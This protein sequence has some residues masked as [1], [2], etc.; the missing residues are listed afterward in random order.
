MNRRIFILKYWKGS[1]TRNCR[2]A[3]PKI[4]SHLVLVNFCWLCETL[5]DYIFA[6]NFFCILSTLQYLS[7]FYFYDEKIPLKPRMTIKTIILNG[8]YIY[9]II[10]FNTDQS[11]VRRLN[12]AWVKSLIKCRKIKAYEK[13]TFN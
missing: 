10:Q 4:V 8:Y 12:L 7:T 13:G 1:F 11:T 3:S 5:T 6:K 2:I 9:I